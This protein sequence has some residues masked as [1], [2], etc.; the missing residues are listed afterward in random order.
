M[1]AWGVQGT[2]RAEERKP[3]AEEGGS[4]H[5]AGEEHGGVGVSRQGRVTEAGSRGPGLSGSF[6]G[7]ADHCEAEVPEA[8][9]TP[10]AG[11]EVDAPQDDA[12][13]PIHT[14]LPEGRQVSQQLLFC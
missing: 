8:L 9:Q 7:K 2:S 1:A 11:R 4:K 13:G 10:D 14:A 5:G 6:P 3:S 12:G